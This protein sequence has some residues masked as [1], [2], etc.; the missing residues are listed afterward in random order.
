MSVARNIAPTRDQH[1]EFN[2]FVQ[3]RT[4]LVHEVTF[5]VPLIPVNDVHAAIDRECVNDIHLIRRYQLIL[6][7]IWFSTSVQVFRSV[8]PRH[9]NEHMLCV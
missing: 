2:A 8:E 1:P 9:T 5:I 3:N 4:H 7:V 6:P